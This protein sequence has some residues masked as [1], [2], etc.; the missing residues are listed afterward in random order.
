[1]LER[2]QQRLL[3]YVNRTIAIID[4]TPT[5]MVDLAGSP[6]TVPKGTGLLNNS[7][8]DMTFVCPRGTRKIYVSIVT[9]CKNEVDTYKL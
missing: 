3:I 8:M 5:R 2:Q 7:E 4:G 9:M 6:N 1:M